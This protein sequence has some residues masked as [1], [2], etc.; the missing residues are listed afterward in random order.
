MS[1]SNFLLSDIITI[2]GIGTKTRKYLQK[3]KIE[4]E[5]DL[6]LDLPYSFIEKSKI[7]SLNELEIGKI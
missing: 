6:L 7:T 3:K 5:K 2:K 1:N 4:K